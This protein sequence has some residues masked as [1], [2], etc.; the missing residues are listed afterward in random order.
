MI[1]K[2]KIKDFAIIDDINIDFNPGLTVITGETGSGKS[3]ILEA[4]SSLINGKFSKSAIKYGASRSVLDLEFD[5]RSYRKIYNKT[6]R[7]KSYIDEAPITQNDFL[8]SFESRVEFHGQN[9]QQIILKAENQID[10]LDYFCNNKKDLTK[11]KIIFDDLEKCKKDLI[12]LN[13]NTAQYKQKK[14]LLEFQ[15][16][17]IQMADIKENEEEKLLQDYKKLNNQED[18]IKKLNNVKQ[19]LNDYENGVVSRL[20]NLSTELNQVLKYDNSVKDFTEII[21]SMIM[22]LQEMEIDIEA[23]LST[24][25]FDSSRLPNIEERISLFEQLKRKYGGSIE[26]IFENEKQIRYELNRISNYAKSD[27]ELKNQIAEL[28]DEYT[29]IAFK[30]SEK[31]KSNADTLS[32]MIEKSLGVLNMNHAKFDIRL[33]HNETDK[34]FIKNSGTPVKPNSKGI[35]QVEF[36]LSANPGEPLK[37]MSKVASGGEMSRIMLAIKTV[38]QDKNPVSTLIFDEI[39]T[40]ISGETAQKV[41]KHLKK[42]SK[43]KQVICITHLPQIAISAD[44]HLHVTKSVINSNSTSVKAEYLNGDFSRNVIKN[45]FVGEEVETK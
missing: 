31:R 16:N 10:F 7:S 14:E 38:F 18:L 4:I 41:S 32:S 2:I 1:K 8:K 28:E 12:D 39:D 9:D 13:Q 33:S 27:S 22:Q 29:E 17:E 23:R 30:L 42:L 36:Y 40:G 34:S 20:T 45:L 15:L 6:G 37:P 44:N 26:S 24:D 21:S 19:S 35:D 25:D 5:K 43:Y 3:I 11:I